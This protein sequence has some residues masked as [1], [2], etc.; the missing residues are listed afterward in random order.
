MEAP[1]RALGAV[2]EPG[3]SLAAAHVSGPDPAAAPQWTTHVSFAPPPQAPAPLAVG[4]HRTPEDPLWTTC[5][6][7]SRLCWVGT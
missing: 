2:P 5:T 4:T 7:F 6:D 1:K 3:C